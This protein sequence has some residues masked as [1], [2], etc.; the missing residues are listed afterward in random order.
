MNTQIFYLDNGFLVQIWKQVLQRSDD[1][2]INRI[3][4]NS[5]IDSI[6]LRSSSNNPEMTMPF[7]SIN[8]DIELQYSSFVYDKEKT[9]IENF[10]KGNGF[11]LKTKVL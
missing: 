3:Y 7:L 2:I 9:K 4:K 5:V 10:L 8:C 6:T 11:T 1:V